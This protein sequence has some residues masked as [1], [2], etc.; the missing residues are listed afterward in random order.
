MILF[1]FFTPFYSF[2]ATEVHIK[3]M[4]GVPQM[5]NGDVK[6]NEVIFF[7]KKLMELD[8]KN[9][10]LESQVKELRNNKKDV[11]EIV[12][13][14]NT[15]YN[16]SFS[17]LQNM[18]AA[19]I[20]LFGGV[21]PLIISFYQTNRLKVESRNLEKKIAAEFHS[22]LEELAEKVKQD[23]IESLNKIEVEFRKYIASMKDET[24]V[25]LKN[26]KSECF[27]LVYH[28]TANAFGRELKWRAFLENALK[29][30]INYADT[31]NK[32]NFNR[33][34]S[35]LRNAIVK[36][37]ITKKSMESNLELYERFLKKMKSSGRYNT[38][39]IELNE[40]DSGWNKIM[41]AKE[42]VET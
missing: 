18:L 33:I 42:E 20:A 3:N 2:A 28:S 29:A 6:T 23:Q 38:N 32:S 40:I 19:V 9:K 11:F 25:E 17:S 1:L 41:K 27:G 39:S 7:Q 34:I 37:V 10:E 13:K 31:N 15:F 22:K 4:D 24:S 16:N 26:I 21:V 30:A 35:T 12:D 8:L 5:K 14:V 36:E